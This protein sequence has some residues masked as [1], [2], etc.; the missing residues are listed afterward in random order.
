MCLP[1]GARRRWRHGEVVEANGGDSGDVQDVLAE[2][3]DDD[4]DSDG[5]RGAVD[6]RDD[7]GFQANCIATEVG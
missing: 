1:G 2:L 4:T 7:G 3:P 6:E 5:G